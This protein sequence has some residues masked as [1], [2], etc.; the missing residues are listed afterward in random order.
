MRELGQDATKDRGL[1]HVSH[2]LETADRNPRPHIRLQKLL[3]GPG[4]AAG[5]PLSDL[6]QE[7]ARQ[8]S[9]MSRREVEQIVPQSKRE[10]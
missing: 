2:L 6:G 4:L 1:P 3:P 8:R 10:P 9:R 5:T 7:V